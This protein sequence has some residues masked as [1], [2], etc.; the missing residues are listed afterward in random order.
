[1]VAADAFERVYW[2]Q[3]ASELKPFPPLHGDSRCDVTIIGGGIMGLACAIALRE[4]GVAVIL[5][6][7]AQ[8]GMGASGRNGGLVVPSLPRLGPL[9]VVRLLGEPH[10]YRLNAM[11][12][13]SAQRVF[14]TVARF[15]IACE[16]E[17]A[18]WINPAHGAGLVEGLQRRVAD[19]QAAGARSTWLDAVQTRDITGSPHYFGALFDASGGHLNPL[20]YT[21]GLA[22]VAQRLGAE[23]Y[24]DSTVENVARHGNRWRV[25]T[26][27]GRVSSDVILQCTNA[28]ESAAKSSLSGDVQ[29]SFVPLHVYQLASRKLTKAERATILRTRSALSDTRNNLFACRYTADHRLV[30]GGMAPMTHWRATQWLK[31]LL[32]GR[33][34]KIFP[35]L[36][37]IEFDFLWRGTAALTPDFL[38]RLFQVAE[39]WFAPLGCNG[40]GIAMSTSIGATLAN[41]VVDND[42]GSL[43]L[44]I[45]RA[46]PIAYHELARFA[47]QWLLVPGMIQDS[48][49]ARVP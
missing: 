29:R 41:Y 20:A 6:D 12:A 17:Q 28:M 44:P 32:S 3:S 9:D 31:P 49:R 19:W 47:P 7:A 34:A 36:D 10:G 46:A 30:T 2:R 42:S 48:I 40:R 16:A 5:L 8:P 23:V 35:Q 13:G 21:R 39:G 25:D 26:A 4:R 37:G 15:G 38:P 24:G 27:S 22:S 43:P 11:V 1:M 14:D 18:G 33:M 45:T